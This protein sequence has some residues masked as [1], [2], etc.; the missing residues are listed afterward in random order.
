MPIGTLIVSHVNFVIRNSPISVFF[1]MQE[2][3]F[4]ENVMKERKLLELVNTFATNVMLSSRKLISSSE[5]ILSIHTTLTVGDA[6]W[7]LQKM[8]GR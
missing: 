6:G 5:E 3:L 1:E 4:V 7:S 2:E 8:P